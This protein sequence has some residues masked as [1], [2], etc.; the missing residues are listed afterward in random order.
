MS[1]K[2]R[3]FSA[4]RAAW[5]RAWVTGRPVSNVS[6]SAIRSAR[7]SMASAIWFRIRARGRA[8]RAR[9]G[10]RVLFEARGARRGGRAGRGGAAERGGS[11]GGG[12][13]DFLGAARRDGGVGHVGHRVGDVEGGAVRA[14]HGRAA[15]EVLQF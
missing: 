6:S 15:D 7:P 5:P 11:G 13:A 8:G 4:A 9:G 10:V 12:A 2:N 14:G 1:A 3:K